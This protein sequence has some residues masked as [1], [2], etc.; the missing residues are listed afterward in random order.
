MNPQKKVIVLTGAPSTGKSTTME[1]VS[2]ILGHDAVIVPE[3]AVVLLSGGFP[4][5]DHHDMEQITAFQKAVIQVHTGLEIV[6]AN[7][8]PDSNLTIFDR[9]ILDG[10]G[11]W[12]PGPEDYLKKF[13]IDV[14]HEFIKYNTV[15]FFELPGEEFY[16]GLNRLRFHNYAQSLESEKKLKQIWN[17]H[18]HFIEINA[19]QVFE[20]KIQAA[21]AII[22]KIAS[23]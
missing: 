8:H 19:T 21:I 15:L 18:P 16:G 2:L 9:G 22:L 3:S 17:K 11:F 4:A 10:G 23:D 13:N 7:Q 1:R 5:P 12:P 20:D 14:A 6:F